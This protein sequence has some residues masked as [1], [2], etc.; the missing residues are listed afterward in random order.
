MATMAS[1]ITAKGASAI[2]S[3]H[4]LGAEAESIVRSIFKSRSGKQADLSLGKIL[5]GSIVK[6]EE[7]IDDVVVGCEGKESFVINCHGNAI[8]VEMIMT[9]LQEKGASVVGPECTISNQ[10][11]D[12]NTIAKEVRI[13]QGRAVTLEGVRIINRQ[14]QNGLDNISGMWLDGL[15]DIT[16]NEIRSKCKEILEASRRAKPFISGCRVVIAGAPNSGKSMLLNY[17]CGKEKAIVTAH[18]GTTRDWVSARC[19][20]RGLMVE[21]FDTAGLDGGLVSDGSA[22]MQAQGRSIELIEN[23]DLVLGVVDSSNVS[24]C[25]WYERVAVCGVKLLVVLN[26]SDLKPDAG[27]GCL[28][29]DADGVIYISAKSGEGCDALAAKIYELL[30]EGDVGEGDVVCFTDRQRD[31]VGH[32]AEVSTQ[33]E[34]KS[35]LEELLNGNLFV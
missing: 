34:A 20:V 31:I 30:A 24:K 16:L 11:A 1:V 13:E 28:R 15:D 8:I 29:F 23:C 14:L 10:L 9:L 35:L 19:R 22:D 2:A 5:S 18:A 33:E 12:Q 7:I 3:I 4:L 26:K 25:D 21:F 6:D 32:L 27:A 17:F